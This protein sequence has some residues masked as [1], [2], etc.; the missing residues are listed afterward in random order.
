MSGDIEPDPKQRFSD[1][2]DDYVKYRPGYPAPA[3][4]AVLTGLGPPAA[5]RAA[6]VGAGTGISARLLAERGVDVIGVEP[7]RA[8]RE[9][10][11]PAAGVRY[12]NGTAEST[13]IESASLDLVLCAQ[14]F[15]WFDAQAAVNEFARI[16]RPCGRLAL[17]WNR[18][19]TSDPLT[20]GYRQA[21]LDIG[22]E[23][24]A[25]QM[26]FDPDVIARS[27]AFSKLRVATFPSQQQLDEV[28]LLGRALSASY[29]P[30]AGV[31]SE[32]LRELLHELHRRHAGADGRVTLVY[33]TE[34]YT[35]ERLQLAP[36]RAS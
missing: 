2:A 4:D 20:A 34:V 18:R 15:H 11:A 27:G 35:A 28:G 1:R 29:A 9:A 19:S 31:A 12:C 33:S 6:D 22:G 5:L 16:L 26:E 23:S 24:R 25:E 32:Q 14:S 8:M 13:G 10:A 3:L 7:N 36:S 17:M 30:K 21:L